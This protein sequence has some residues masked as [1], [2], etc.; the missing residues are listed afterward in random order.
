[1][2][3]I[4]FYHGGNSPPS[5]QLRTRHMLIYKENFKLGDDHFLGN[6]KRRAHAL[7]ASHGRSSFHARQCETFIFENITYSYKKISCSYACDQE[8]I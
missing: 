5:R 6:S 4:K 1:M 2:P 3:S 7:D 8:I